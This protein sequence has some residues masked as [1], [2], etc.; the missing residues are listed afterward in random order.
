MQKPALGRLTEKN[1][2]P[3]APADQSPI[4][5]PP[6]PNAASGS[7]LTPDPSSSGS[8]LD[9]SSGEKSP[10]RKKS[11]SRSK[12]SLSL[13]QKEIK[14]V[15]TAIPLLQ[16]LSS[17]VTTLNN[18]VS[19]L[20]S[21]N[22]SSHRHRPS[23]LFGRSSHASSVLPSIADNAK[24]PAPPKQS[25]PRPPSQPPAFSVPPLTITGTNP[26][27]TT[28]VT[29]RWP[30]VDKNHIE[31]IINGKFDINNLPK[32]FRDEQSRREHS[33]QTVTGVLFPLAG[34][35]VEIIPGTARLQNVFHSLP[36]FLSAFLV[37]VSIRATY[38]PEY[39]TTIPL[40]IERLSNY[41]AKGSWPPVLAYAIE[42]FQTHQS[43][44]AT[45]WL[46]TDGELISLHFAF[47]RQLQPSPSRPASSKKSIGNNRDLSQYGCKNFNHPTGRKYSQFHE[48]STCCRK[49]ARISPNRSITPGHLPPSPSHSKPL[50]PE[51]HST[52]PHAPTVSPKHNPRLTLPHPHTIRPI[53]TPPPPPLPPC[54]PSLPPNS[55]SPQ[56]IPAV[57]HTP[58]LTPFLTTGQHHS[59]RP[60]TT[61]HLPL[62]T[63]C[64]P[65]LPPNSLC[66]Q[67]IPITPTHHSP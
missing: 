67:G 8:E 12:K 7:A 66:P 56:G 48:G 40:W 46:E 24:P 16:K 4:T 44:P 58:F 36:T 3:P 34:G 41:T 26:S 39:G 57:T 23:N 65:S 20:D 21:S 43:A 35:S 53:I 50:S 28:D 55:L 1:K 18:A 29:K 10:P 45:K 27:P 63:P 49:A 64:D 6:P 47:A 59:P 33:T 25:S 38:A 9:S 37:Y 30:W 51:N 60:K 61:P 14:S 5:T 13:L 17:L 32:L 19:R 31:Q 54:D 11:R 15:R 42:Y 62:V 52:S 22:Q 2:Q